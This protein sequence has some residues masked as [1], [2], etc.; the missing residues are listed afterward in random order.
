MVSLNTSRY[1]DTDCTGMIVAVHN[2]LLGKLNEAYLYK[3]PEEAEED[4]DLLS[5]EYHEVNLREVDIVI[6]K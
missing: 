5:H 6:V 1:A 3:D 4:L 2:I